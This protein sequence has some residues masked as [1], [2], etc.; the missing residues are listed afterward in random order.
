MS[1][2]YPALPHGAGLIILSLAYFTTFASIVSG[3]FMEMAEV[4]TG[5]KSND[6]MDFVRALASLQ[7]ACGVDNLKMSEWTITEEDLPRFV[8]NARENMGGLFRVDPAPLT[9]D[10]FLKI[11]KDSYR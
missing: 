11:Y 4:M 1:A 8:Q 9:D 7:K 10:V 3:R 2:Y 5:E 6:P